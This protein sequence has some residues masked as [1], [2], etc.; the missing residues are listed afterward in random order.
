[1]HDFLIG[2]IV[3]PTGQCTDLLCVSGG[4]ANRNTWFRQEGAVAHFA[5]RYNNV[6]PPLTTISR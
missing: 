2:F 1:V 4:K 5:L 6:S 3:T